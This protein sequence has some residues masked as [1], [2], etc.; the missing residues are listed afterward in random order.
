MGGALT[1]VVV[2][3][4]RV[5][6]SRMANARAGETDVRALSSGPAKLSASEPSLRRA[7]E[8]Q[9]ARARHPPLA[10]NSPDSRPWAA[11]FKNPHQN[12]HLVAMRRLKD[13]RSPGGNP[14]AHV[15]WSSPGV[16]D[17][18]K[19]TSRHAHAQARSDAFRK[20]RQIC[21]VLGNERCERTRCTVDHEFVYVS[22]YEA[23]ADVAARLP[24]VIEEIYNAER[25]DTTLGC[26]AN[27]DVCNV[28]KCEST[29]WRDGV[30][31]P[32]LACQ[33]LQ[34]KA[35]RLVEHRDKCVGTQ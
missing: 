21:G 31:I 28:D 11:L 3:V 26:P 14:V 6:A 10:L 22:G 27:A 24:R 16:E 18:V 17:I 20:T 33:P 29:W 32:A 23:L 34:R 7:V 35:R 4:G 12:L 8:L 15:S 25:L 9:S 30:P 13:E 19:L 1:G 2:V 5:G